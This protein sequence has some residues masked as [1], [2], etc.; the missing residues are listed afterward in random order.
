MNNAKARNN[1]KASTSIE[2]DNRNFINAPPNSEK[3]KFTIASLKL[4]NRML[5]FQNNPIPKNPK[6]RAS[7]TYF[8]S[9]LQ[10]R[11]VASTILINTFEGNCTTQKEIREKTGLSKGM[12]SK[13]CSE[14]VEAGWFH[15][16]YLSDYT[17]CYMTD[18]LINNSA[19]YYTTNMWSDTDDPILIEFCRRFDIMYM[20]NKL[21]E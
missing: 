16:K 19:S 3:L 7:S 12:V 11:L 1:Q 18:E 10:K 2:K 6:E 13:I 9:S 8:R 21:D 15:I 5:N 17:P 20:Q 4:E 14:C